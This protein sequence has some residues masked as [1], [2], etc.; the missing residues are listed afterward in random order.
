MLRK[1]VLLA[2]KYPMKIA[3]LP[4]IEYISRSFA[5]TKNVAYKL[6]KQQGTL[7]Q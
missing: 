7:V 4:V 5:P 2:D 1:Q 3:P 6:A